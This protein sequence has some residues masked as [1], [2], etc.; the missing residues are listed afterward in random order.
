MKFKKDPAPLYLQVMNAVAEMLRSYKPNERLPREADL[1]AEFA[2][3]R[4]TIREALSALEREG[5]V[6]RRQGV[7]T[8]VADKAHLSHSLERLRSF[9]E[10]LRDHGLEPG[11]KS[12]NTRQEPADDRTASALNIVR[13]TPLLVVERVRTGNGEPLIYSID[14][15]PLQLLQVSP[16]SEE[17]KGSLFS[18]LER[19]GIKLAY[20]DTTITSV[21]PDIAIRTALEMN[22]GVPVILFDEVSYD[23]SRKPVMCS[24]NYFKSTRYELKII[25]RR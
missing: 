11:S 1:A 3:S 14:K 9:S 18:I 20:A 4:A 16:D 21:I 15:I 2:V 5:L 12:V 22:R 17:L 7:G 19:Q 23:E 24:K 10:L 6:Y 25:R 8:F 13:G